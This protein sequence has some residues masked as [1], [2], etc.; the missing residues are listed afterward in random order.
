MASILDALLPFEHCPG[1]GHRL[2]DPGY[3][4]VLSTQQGRRALPVC[5]NCASLM[6]SVSDR[7]PQLRSLLDAAAVSRHDVWPVHGEW[8]LARTATAPPLGQPALDHR[9]AVVAYSSLY[10]DQSEGIEHAETLVAELIAST[11]RPLPE[12]ALL[13]DIIGAP[14]QVVKGPAG[15]LARHLIAFVD[16]EFPGLHSRLVG[17]TGHESVRPARD[18]FVLRSLD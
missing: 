9:L 6:S 17:V 8:A 5:W 10:L 13:C 4:V 16:A 3:L 18:G 15:A 1:C 2:G 14:A 11:E 12:I 7:H